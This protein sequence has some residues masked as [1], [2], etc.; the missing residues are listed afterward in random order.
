MT[1]SD[2]ALL[3]FLLIFAAAVFYF[4]FIHGGKA[5]PTMTPPKPRAHDWA[6]EGGPAFPAQTSTLYFKGM[7]LR[8]TLRDWFAGMALQ[9]IV[10][11]EGAIQN[12]ESKIGG[13]VLKD[14]VHRA[15]AYADAM[16]KE[17]EPPPPQ[18]AET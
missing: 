3:C 14:D 13:D 15:Y 7:S 16:L 10:V 9:A 17:R 4:A 5:G 2:F 1:A 6:K 11:H 12:P 18:S 8:D